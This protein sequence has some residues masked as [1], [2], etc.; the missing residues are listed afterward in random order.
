M[1]LW[2]AFFIIC[3]CA[4]YIISIILLNKRHARQLAEISGE[5]IDENN[6]GEGDDE[7]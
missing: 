1:Y 4:V 6:E 2:E 7:K 5:N 3:L